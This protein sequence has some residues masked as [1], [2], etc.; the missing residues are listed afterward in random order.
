M[1]KKSCDLSAEEFTNSKGYRRGISDRRNNLGKL[2]NPYPITDDWH[3]RWI[4]GWHDQD[5]EFKFELNA[6]P[7]RKAAW[8]EAQ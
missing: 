2:A 1:K 6:K 3:C 4:A 8:L 7:K 5:I